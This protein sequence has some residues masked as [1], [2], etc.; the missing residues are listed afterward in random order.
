MPVA[1][2]CAAHTYTTRAFAQGKCRRI[3]TTNLLER[4]F[5]EQRRR[6]KTIPRFFT[7]KS[8]L[9]RSLPHCGEPA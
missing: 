3:R 9:K 4:S 5:L 7:E 6:I 2:T 8:C 1:P